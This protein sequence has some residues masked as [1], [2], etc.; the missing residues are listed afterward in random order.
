MAVRK[1]IR[2]RDDGDLRRELKVAFR[3]QGP[4]ERPVATSSDH[5][6]PSRH[7]VVALE[8]TGASPNIDLLPAANEQLEWQ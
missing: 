1:R 6:G 5:L 3:E 7:D 4:G 2:V 8:R